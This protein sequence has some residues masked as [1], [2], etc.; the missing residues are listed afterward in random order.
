MSLALIIH[1]GSHLKKM[2]LCDE[3][4]KIINAFSLPVSELEKTED[5]IAFY[6]EQ[7]GIKEYP[8]VAIIAVSSPVFDGEDIIHIKNNFYPLIISK[9]KNKFNFEIIEVHNNFYMNAYEFPFIAQSEFLEIGAH[10]KKRFDNQPKG[11]IGIGEGLGTALIISNTA[12]ENIIVPCEAGHLDL[13]V[14]KD[15]EQAQVVK[16]LVKEYNVREV[17]DVLS[18]HG[19]ENIYLAYC[20]IDKKPKEYSRFLDIMNAAIKGNSTASKAVKIFFEMMGMFAGNFALSTGTYGGIYFVSSSCLIHNYEFLEA[21]NESNFRKFFDEADNI[22]YLEHIPTYVCTSEA[23][24]FLGLARY[25][26]KVLQKYQG[27]K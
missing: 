15:A 24:V 2:A 27:L 4:G 5:A 22:D 13:F 3:S 20:Q 21:M 9:I 14:C 6:F 23:P 19:L 10:I 7:L 17:E 25:T 1:C 12:G 8:K 26:A 11:L 18:H 16:Y